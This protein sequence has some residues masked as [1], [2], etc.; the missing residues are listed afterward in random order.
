MLNLPDSKSMVKM[1][2]KILPS[3]VSPEQFSLLKQCICSELR[4]K[5]LA[6]LRKINIG[7]LKLVLV[8]DDRL[9]GVTPQLLEKVSQNAG[10]NFHASAANL[11]Y[12]MS[13]RHFHIYPNRPLPVR[14]CREQAENGLSAS[15]WPPATSRS[16]KKRSP[17]STHG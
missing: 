5:M 6:H 13:E 2:R 4:A 17:P 10:N 1:L 9:C 15:F 12:E 7:A 11:F 3:T 14:L 16:E 8:P